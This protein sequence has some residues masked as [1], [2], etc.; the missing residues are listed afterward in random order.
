MLKRVKDEPGFARD[1]ESNAI[2]SI[3]ES[4]L[5]AYKKRRE[6]RIQNENMY[7]DINSLKAEMAQIKN[8]MRLLLDREK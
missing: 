5:Q 2:I 3:D 1:T 4:G 6:K 7:D 8:M